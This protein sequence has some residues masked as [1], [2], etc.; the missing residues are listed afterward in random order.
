MRDQ[1]RLQQLVEMAY[2]FEERSTL[3]AD[4]FVAWV[5]QQRKPDPSDALV[6][7]MTIHGAKGLEF[8]V[9]VLP[10]LEASL[11]GRP[12]RFVV[13]RDPLSLAARFVCRYVGDDVQKLLP[14]EQQKAFAEERQHRV[15]ESLSLLYVAMTRAACALHMYVP[16]PRTKKRNNS[17]CNLLSQTL[18]PNKPCTESALLYEHGVRDW[19]LRSQ[20]EPAN[21]PAPLAA[22]PIQTITFRAA[23]PERRRGLE[24]AA[25][26]HR[27]GGAK[28]AV[29]K[30]F[31]PRA[32]TGMAVGT[33]MHAWFELIEWLDDGAPTRD[34][35]QAAADKLRQCL[36]LGI[37]Q[38]RESLLDRFEQILQ[39]PDVRNVLSRTAYKGPSQPGYPLALAGYWTPY[40]VPHTVERERRFIV[41]NDA[42][43]WDG[44]VD[45]LVW[46]GDGNRT[47]AA[48][49]IDFKTDDV[50]PDDAAALAERTEHYRPQI[51]AYRT[52]VARL[53]A[54]SPRCIAAR[55]VFTHAGKVVEL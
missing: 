17:W 51:D 38:T 20:P 36:P 24:H 40:L 16:G 11:V 4:G 5:R 43:F 1:S 8:D 2:E 15:E 42:K 10:E 45:R 53:G 9:V 6:R 55:L 31:D 29:K 19:H 23:D 52:A 34:A 49:I 30:L 18:A 13:R 54:L 41:R 14:T 37:W 21:K 28:V 27:E 25:P 32:D 39:K 33:L 22:A 7:V 50:V 35:C 12:P 26:S 47:V 46:L 3:R 44:S 48:D